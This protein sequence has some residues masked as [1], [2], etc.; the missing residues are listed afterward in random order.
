MSLQQ[1]THTLG[2]TL[3]EEEVPLDVLRATTRA[4]IKI[5]SHEYECDYIQVLDW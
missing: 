2:P 5:Y 4:H 3:H 1:M